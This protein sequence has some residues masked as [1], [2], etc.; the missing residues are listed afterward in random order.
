MNDKEKIEHW[1]NA[2]DKERHL[3][4]RLIRFIE[5]IESLTN[6]WDYLCDCGQKGGMHLKDCMTIS[7]RLTLDEALYPKKEK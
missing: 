6:N 4:E 3:S 2:Y 7:A 1:R 5:S